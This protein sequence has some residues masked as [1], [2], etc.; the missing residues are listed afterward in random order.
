MGK[1]GLYKPTAAN[2]CCIDVSLGLSTMYF[3]KKHTASG[4]QKLLYV[5]GTLNKQHQYLRI[6]CMSN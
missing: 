6:L 4:N 3:P 1:G 2:S 5:V